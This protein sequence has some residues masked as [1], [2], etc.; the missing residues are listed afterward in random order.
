M[1]VSLKYNNEILFS[2]P[3]CHT[4]LQ[5]VPYLH[6]KCVRRPPPRAAITTSANAM[7]GEVPGGM[8]LYPDEKGCY[9]VCENEDITVSAAPMQ[10]SI[11]CVGYVV[12]EKVSRAH[13]SINC[14]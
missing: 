9:R 8:D 5:E 7:Y 3:A 2:D 1:C 4:C 11:P 13:S 10:H 12:L 14:W 6:G